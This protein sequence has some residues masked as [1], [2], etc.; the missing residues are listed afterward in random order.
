[1][2]GGI[3]NSKNKFELGSLFVYTP[4]HISDKFEVD[5]FLT[6]LLYLYN[7]PHVECNLI[8]N[9]YPILKYRDNVNR[10]IKLD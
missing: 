9:D 3:L 5:T 2:S 10:L 7:N 1:M 8:V 6:P 4:N